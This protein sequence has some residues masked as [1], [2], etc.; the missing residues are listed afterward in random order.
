MNSKFSN[1]QCKHYFELLF[2]YSTSVVLER[3]ILES[4][5]WSSEIVSIQKKKNWVWSNS[6]NQACYQMTAFAGYA[7]SS[8]MFYTLV[9]FV[10]KVSFISVNYSTWEWFLAKWVSLSRNKFVIKLYGYADKPLHLKALMKVRWTWKRRFESL[11][12]EISTYEQV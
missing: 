3:K 1:F 6:A 12:P 11:F 9:P 7:A 10:L 2:H 8:F 4:V 5:T